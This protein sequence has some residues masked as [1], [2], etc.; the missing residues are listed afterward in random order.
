MVIRLLWLRTPLPSIPLSSR[1]REGDFDRRMQTRSPSLALPGRGPGGGAFRRTKTSEAERCASP[2]QSPS[3]AELER[4]TLIAG[5]KH[6]PPL[7]LC[8]GGGQ[9]EGPSAH[10]IRLGVL[11]WCTGGAALLAPVGAYGHTLLRDHFANSIPAG[12]DYRVALE[13][14]LCAMPCTPCLACGVHNTL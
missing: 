5:C 3:P 11:S 13:R 8:R 1:A 4:G 6:V 14:S 9:G 12:R 2:P 10:T 7:W